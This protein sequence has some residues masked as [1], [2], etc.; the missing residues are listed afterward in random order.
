[1]STVNSL[2]LN[3][4]LPNK[5]GSSRDAAYAV[6]AGFLGWTL[7]AASQWTPPIHTMTTKKK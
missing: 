2:D 5:G 7:A 6:I 3:S 1:M 4:P